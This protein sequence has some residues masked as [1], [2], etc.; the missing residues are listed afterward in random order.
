MSNTIQERVA[1]MKDIRKRLGKTQEEVAAE[2]KMD[3]SYYSRKECETSEVEFNHLE[4]QTIMDYFIKCEKE[5]DTTFDGQAAKL[6]SL[7]DTPNDNSCLDNVFDIDLVRELRRRGWEV[8]V[9]ISNDR[10]KVD[11]IPLTP[12]TI[13]QAMTNNKNVKAKAARELGYSREHFSK[14]YSEMVKVG[15]LIE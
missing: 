14:V 12:D 11:K 2:I 13:K 3:R 4:L 10:G 1:I 5:F 6:I 7:I 9:S 8:K 15:T